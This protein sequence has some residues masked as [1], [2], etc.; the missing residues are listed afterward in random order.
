MSVNMSADDGMGGEKKLVLRRSQSSFLWYFG[1]RPWGSNHSTPQQ[2]PDLEMGKEVA[3]AN[4]AKQLS[5]P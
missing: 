4:E 5:K 2:L 1:A 3:E